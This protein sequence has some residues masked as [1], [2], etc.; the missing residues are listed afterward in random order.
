MR[1]LRA[2]LGDT[3]TILT[4]N[5]TLMWPIFLLA[6]IW[7]LVDQGVSA[8]AAYHFD[9]I[10]IGRVIVWFSIEMAFMAG[11]CHM[12]YQAAYRVLRPNKEKPPSPL[13]SLTLLQEFFPGVSAFFPSFFFGG[14]IQALF[15]G[16]LIFGGYY[17]LENYLGGYP[18]SLNTLFA[19]SAAEPQTVEQVQK[20]I[21]GL[22]S[23][24]HFQII[25]LGLLSI[26]GA[27]IF[28]LFY[29][30]TMY[31]PAYV[32]IHD[33]AAPTAYLKSIRQVLRDPLHAIVIFFAYLIVQ[34]VLITLLS[35]TNIFL[36]ML[37]FLFVLMSHIWLLLMVSYYV[38]AK[39]PKAET[40]ENNGHGKLSLKA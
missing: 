35:N 11:M 27:G 16:L 18:T 20:Y 1:F 3:F 12:A 29:L 39:T 10:A 21:L 31:W 32:I 26:T 2:L 25:K 17:A 4:Q 24:E 9:P 30:F 34:V 6:G 15:I 5:L 14:L 23:H 28:G 36:S 8:E 40:K 22:S 7:L 19:Q 13:D 33:I 38:I 37:L